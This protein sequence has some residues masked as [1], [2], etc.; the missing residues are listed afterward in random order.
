VTVTAVITITMNGDMRW[1][2]TCTHCPMWEILNQ[3]YMVFRRQRQGHIQ[4]HRNE[5]H[6]VEQ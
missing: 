6:Q 1:S 4:R 5:G 3:P 2:A